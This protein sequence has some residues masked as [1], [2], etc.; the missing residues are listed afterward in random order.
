MNMDE[1]QTAVRQTLTSFVNG[2]ITIRAATFE[3]E[4]LMRNAD[5]DI[6]F[7][8]DFIRFGN[9]FR[10]TFDRYNPT[11]AASRGSERTFWSKVAEPFTG[12]STISIQE[13]RDRTIVFLRRWNP[14][15]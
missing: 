2:E 7:M 8:P 15:R 6:Y 9:H 14:T 13:V 3:C 10:A 1:F 12:D 11:L 5:P 4:Q